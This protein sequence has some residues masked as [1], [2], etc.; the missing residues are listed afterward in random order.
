M[1]AAQKPLISQIGD[2]GR[3]S[4]GLKAVAGIGKQRLAHRT[5]GQPVR[6]GVGP[7]HFVKHHALVAGLSLWI[8][9]IMPALLVK[10]FRAGA[11][12]R[13]EN[14]IQIDPH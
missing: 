8:E 6:V 12:E 5:C 13:M 10:N 1:V 2:T 7:L 11:D 9:L 14:R 3:V 4:P